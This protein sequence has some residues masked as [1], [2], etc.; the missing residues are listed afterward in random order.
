MAFTRR[1]HIVRVPMDD[2]PVDEG[3][4]PNEYI[5]MEVLDAIA[6]R[7]EGNQEVIL[8]MD[9]AKAVPYIVDDTGGGHGKKSGSATRRTHMER[10]KGKD[11]HMIDIEAIDCWSARDQRGEEWVLDMQSSNDPFDISDGSGSSKSTRRAHDEVVSMPFGTKKKDA[12]TDYLTVQRNDNIA[13]RKVRNQEVI[14]SIPSCDDPN[15]PNVQFGRASTF[16]TPANYDPSDDSSDA[17][18]PPLI[19]KTDDLHNYVKPVK[20]ASGFLT[21]DEKIKMGPFW[22]IRK[23][24]SGVVYLWFHLVSRDEP[25]QPPTAAA[26]TITIRKDKTDF[27]ILYDQTVR[28]ATDGLPVWYAWYPAQTALVILHEG[29]IGYRTWGS[30]TIEDAVKGIT[31]EGY[32]VNDVWGGGRVSP[33]SNTFTHPTTYFTIGDSNGV[34]GSA[35]HTSGPLFFE[36]EADAQAYVDFANVG[37]GGDIPLLSVGFVEDPTVQTFTRDVIIQ[38]GA[39]SKFFADVH[40][41]GDHK[42]MTVEVFQKAKN[43]PPKPKLD[44]KNVTPTTLPNAIPADSSSGCKGDQS[45]YTVEVTRDTEKPDPP[46]TLKLLFVD[47]EPPT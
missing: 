12:G 24:Q 17:V 46:E 43:R 9:T 13:F 15:S 45:T 44:P 30:L 16:T 34:P 1:T 28:G 19:D 18:T 7:I 23:V 31:V 29:G 10:V 25:A 6:F 8:S 21:G 26:P 47:V 2:P 33:L 40:I 42:G 35:L 4:A 36:T 3:E 27:K 11:N 41:V 39:P 20:D 14:I 38:T 22:W 37:A 32:G 5:D